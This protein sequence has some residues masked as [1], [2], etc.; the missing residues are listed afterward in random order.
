[1]KKTYEVLDLRILLV[2]EDVIR[3]SG[4]DSN[5]DEGETDKQNP[6]LFG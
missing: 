2:T 6:F 3:T 1:M 4:G 5:G